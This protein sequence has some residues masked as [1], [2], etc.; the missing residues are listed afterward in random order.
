MFRVES[1]NVQRIVSQWISPLLASSSIRTCC[2]SRQSV[3]DSWRW[4]LCCHVRSV[5]HLDCRGVS[6][7]VQRPV[8]GLCQILPPFPPVLSLQLW[9]KSV[10]QYRGRDLKRRRNYLLS[11]VL[12]VFRPMSKCRVLAEGRLH[13]N[14]RGQPSFSW[15]SCTNIHSAKM[16]FSFKI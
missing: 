1:P 6:S 14:G 10:S 12:R 16:N 7:N 2:E 15:I 11:S 13:Q 5:E 8:E 4:C 9:R 3:S